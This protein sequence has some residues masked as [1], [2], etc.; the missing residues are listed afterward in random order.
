MSEKIKTD[1]RHQILLEFTKIHGVGSSTAR[2]LY[3]QHGCR[4]IG[5]VEKV[6]HLLPS[7]AEDSIA[8][9]SNTVSSHEA[10]NK[11]FLQVIDD[12]DM[13][14]GLTMLT[15]AG[16]KMSLL[17]RIPRAE[18]EEIAETFNQVLQ[19]LI[20]RVSGLG[21]DLQLTQSIYGLARS[22]IYDSWRISKGESRIQ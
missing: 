6:A 22:D 19:A 5:D 7:M 17:R 21:L 3:I 4:T 2:D 12:F 9:K 11:S 18:V 1:P 10:L 16:T 8:R 20:V 15:L 13:K 14:F